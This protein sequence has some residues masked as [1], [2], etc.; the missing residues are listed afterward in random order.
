MAY[1]FIGYDYSYENDE[2]IDIQGE[3][4]LQLIDVCFRYS[5]C[6]SLVYQEK[7]MSIKELNE[8]LVMSKMTNNW[9][10]TRATDYYKIGLYRCN[11][12]TKNL[13]KSHVNSLFSWVSYWGNNNPEDLTFYRSDKSVFLYTVAHEAMATLL[14]RPTENIQEIISV[15]GWKKTNS[16]DMFF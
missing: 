5:T 15:G 13:L 1:D 4:Y 10:G 2:D 8:N 6:F 12:M 11:T 9:P 16:V 7:S 14:E 3:R